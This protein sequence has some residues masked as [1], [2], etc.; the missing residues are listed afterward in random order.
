MAKHLWNIAS[1]KDSIWVR[2]VKIHRLKGGNIWDVE[3]KEHRSWS[4]CP[5]LKLRDDI[6][7]FVN[8][9]IGNGQ[10]CNIW[11]GLGNRRGDLMK[12]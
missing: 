2:W 11:C 3:L 12:L 5:L 9:K 10:K 1:D 7:R 8:I 4:W 6:R